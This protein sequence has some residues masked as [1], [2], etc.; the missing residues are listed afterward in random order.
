M[1]GLEPSA[2]T[3]PRQRSSQTELHPD[4]WQAENYSLP[5]G[6]NSEVYSVC[7]WVG[8]PY[9]LASLTRLVRATGLEPAASWSQTTRSSQTELRPDMW[10]PQAPLI[11]RDTCKYTRQPRE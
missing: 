8:Q 2:S 1:K 9:E 5:I 4:M 10:G 3:T 7:E 6:H 11:K